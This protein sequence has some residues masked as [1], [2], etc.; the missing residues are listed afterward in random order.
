M[1]NLKLWKNVSGDMQRE[2][3]KVAFEINFLNLR[4]GQKKLQTDLR[5]LWFMV[6]VHGKKVVLISFSYSLHDA[7][8][9]KTFLHIKS[10]LHQHSCNLQ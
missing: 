10:Q 7:K 5:I 9:S 4:V 8:I 6:A 2:T 1:G 3:N